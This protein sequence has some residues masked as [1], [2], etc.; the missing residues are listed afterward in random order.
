MAELNCNR[1]LFMLISCNIYQTG[2]DSKTE[3]ES[4]FCLKKNY[5]FCSFLIHYHN[6][7]FSLFWHLMLFSHIS[8]ITKNPNLV[9]H[10]FHC[11]KPDNL[12][13]R[14]H[15]SKAVNSV[16]INCIY[17]NVCSN[18]FIILNIKYS[19][20]MKWLVIHIS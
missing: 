10:K 5:C 1:W 13:N 16:K 7:V 6:L 3:N 19:Y 14:G 15:K 18:V 2:K 4:E 9:S 20:K 8:D 17:N 11:W 12:R